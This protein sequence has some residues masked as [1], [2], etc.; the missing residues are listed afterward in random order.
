MLIAKSTLLFQ[1]NFAA[2]LKAMHSFSA[3]SEK[4]LSL[5]NSDFIVVRKR[6]PKVFVSAT[7]VVYYGTSETQ[8][9]DEQSP[10]GN[11]YLAEMF[12]GGRIGSGKQ[13]YI[14]YLLV[15]ID[16]FPAAS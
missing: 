4:E 2:I 7:A 9:F 12:A 8:V 11:D 15:V 14:P 5:S 13:W 6:R 1:G 10:S 16:W 3:E